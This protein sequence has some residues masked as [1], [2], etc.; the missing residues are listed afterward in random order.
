M[1]LVLKRFPIVFKRVAG[2]VDVGVIVV[3]RC[4]MLSCS[5]RL[6][7]VFVRNFARMAH[8]GLLRMLCCAAAVNPVNVRL[9]GV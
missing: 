1:V 9:G 4:V 6:C 7:G 5:V 3:G 8:P 2:V